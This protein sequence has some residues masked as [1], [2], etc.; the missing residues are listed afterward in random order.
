MDRPEQGRTVQSADGYEFKAAEES[1]IGETA[2]WVGYYS[3]I[4]LIVCALLIGMGVTSLPNGVGMLGLGV[5]YLIIG[6]FFR[7]ASSSMRDVVKTSG[8]DVPHLMVALD[9]L[10]LAFKVQ[11]VLFLAA[12]VGGIAGVVITSG[13]VP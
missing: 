12:L 3:W 4:A 9:R 1:V 8:R 6:L 13:L 5:V 7:G 2:S 10:T 11:V